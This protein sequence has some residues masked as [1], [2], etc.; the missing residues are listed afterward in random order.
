[1]MALSTLHPTQAMLSQ[2]AALRLWRYDDIANP[3]SGRGAR[4]DMESPE[5]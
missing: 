4:D 5:E 3:L 1:M 2:E